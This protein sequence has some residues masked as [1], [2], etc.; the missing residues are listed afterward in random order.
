MKNFLTNESPAQHEYIKGLIQIFCPSC[1]VKWYLQSSSDNS[2]TVM[3]KLPLFSDLYF[4][5]SCVN[6][7]HKTFY[8]KTEDSQ[9]HGLPRC[10]ELDFFK[11][12]FLCCFFYKG[13]T[14]KTDQSKSEAISNTTSSN[15]DSPTDCMYI[16]QIT[17]IK[18]HVQHVLGFS[19]FVSVCFIHTCTCILLPICS[20]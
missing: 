20:F 16:K 13:Q 7:Q 3:R 5:Y 1:T 14:A 12:H 10:Y 11:I 9:K 15:K 4:V 19:F 18:I 17:V 2:I 6:M 8:T